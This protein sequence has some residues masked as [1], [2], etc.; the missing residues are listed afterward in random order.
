MLLAI[1]E[2]DARE[3]K[4]ALVDELLPGALETVERDARIRTRGVD[5][6]FPFQAN[7]H[8][9]PQEVVSDC[10]VGF[11]DGI[12]QEMSARKGSTQIWRAFNFLESVD[13]DG[14]TSMLKAFR[15]FFSARRRRG[16]VVVV[17]DFLDE[18]GWDH[19]SPPPELPAD[20][21]SGT[22]ERYVEAFRRIS[23]SDPIL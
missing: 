8:G 7:L 23:G 21:V 18:T 1:T 3:I 22:L 2:R 14:E 11:A 4:N 10:L 20:V 5:L 9:L 17:S 12:A 16:L 13:A 15:N 19:E 6:P